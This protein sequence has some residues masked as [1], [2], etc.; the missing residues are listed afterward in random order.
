[1]MAMDAALIRISLAL[2]FA[3]GFLGVALSSHEPIGSVQDV[4]DGTLPLARSHF[5]H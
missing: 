5:I 1:M 4:Y 2:V 3:A